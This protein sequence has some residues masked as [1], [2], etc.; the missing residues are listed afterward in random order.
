MSIPL[1][2]PIKPQ[3]EVGHTTDGCITDLA[4][5]LVFNAL[6]INSSPF[7]AGRRA[8]AGT[9]REGELT[10]NAFPGHSQIKSGSGLGTRPVSDTLTSFCAN[11]R[12]QGM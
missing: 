5:P 7:L 10:G 1:L 8:R 11:T 6:V 2:S 12:T 3:V 9:S 4:I